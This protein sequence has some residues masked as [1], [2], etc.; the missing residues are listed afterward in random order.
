VTLSTPI[1]IVALVG[2][3]AALGMG[4]FLM[5]RLSH[6]SDATLPAVVP[7]VQTP[8]HVARTAPVHHATAPVHHAVTGPW[9]GK[10]VPANLSHAL[11][12]HKVVVVVLYAHG[13]AD[14]SG[15][16]AAARQGADETHAGFAA[17]DVR[18]E[19]TAESVASLFPGAADPAVL[20]VRRPGTTVTL[21]DGVQ[22]SMTVAQAAVEARR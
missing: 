20:I 21:L 12:Q 10:S 17:L 11:A 8:H 14:E 5:M 22:E 16:V 7:P 18:N 9:A 2:I 4:A 1:K 6:S 19:K 13:L 3:V 15:V